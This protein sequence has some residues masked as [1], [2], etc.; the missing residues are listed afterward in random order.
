MKIVQGLGWYFPDSLGGTEVYVAAVSRRLRAM[1]HEVAIVAPQ[2]GASAERRYE[3]DGVPVYRYPVPAEVTRAEAQGSATVR[4]A[5]RLHRWLAAERPDVVHLHTFVSGLGLP[6]LRVARDIGARTV[7]TTHSSSLGY[8]CARGDLMRWGAALCDG[9]CVASKCS[10]CV[11]DQRGLSRPMARAVGA[12][13]PPLARAFHH[14]RGPAGTALG[15]SEVIRANRRRQRELLDL[16]DWFVVLTGAARAI[17]LNNGFDGRKIAVNRLGVAFEREAPAAPAAGSGTGRPVT[18]AY[19]GRFDPLKGV[20]VLAR[21]VRLLPSDTP[22]VV[23]FRGPVSTA[24][25]R[26]MVARVRRIVS[27]DPRVR[28][29]PAVP[30]AQILDLLRGYDVVCC[31]AVCLEGGPTVALE[32]HAAGTPV[33]GSRIGGLAELIDDEVNG[34]LT[35]PGDAAAL[36]SALRDLA[37]AP[38]ATIDRWRERLPPPRTMDDVTDEYLPLYAPARDGRRAIAG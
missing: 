23:E 13:P 30:H 14:V 26:A 11:L 9:I 19:V 27:G 12:L 5:E 36:A 22:I 15:M 16:A 20:E 10:A 8:L 31:P 18:V 4:G 24:A 29:A 2:A 33:V 37:R 1:G 28:F 32:A 6:E 34:R 35:P 38:E 7:V 25:E 17:L 3:H 21:A